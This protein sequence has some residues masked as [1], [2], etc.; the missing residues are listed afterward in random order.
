MCYRIILSTFMNK[1]FTYM[2]ISHFIHSM[3]TVI[4]YDVS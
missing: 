3:I 4:N 2:S 1:L